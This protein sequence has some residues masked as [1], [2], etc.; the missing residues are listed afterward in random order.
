MYVLR[1]TEMIL[2]SETPQTLRRAHV[3]LFSCLREEL[4]TGSSLSVAANWM[5][6]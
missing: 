5:S 4:A 3:H 2:E 1:H 6:S